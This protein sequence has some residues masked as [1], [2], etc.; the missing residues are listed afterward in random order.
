MIMSYIGMA[1]M[2][3]VATTLLLV[4]RST[5]DLSDCHCGGLGILR[6]NF[7]VNSRTYHCGTIIRYASANRLAGS[8]HCKAGKVASEIIV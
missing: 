5:L 1:L 4:M 8:S 6:N 3:V 7:G 2:L